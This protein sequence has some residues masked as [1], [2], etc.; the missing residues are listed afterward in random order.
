M[1]LIAMPPCPMLPRSEFL[2]SLTMRVTCLNQFDSAHADRDLAT[3]RMAFKIH[4]L[5]NPRYVQPLKILGL[6]LMW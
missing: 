1:V 6:P 4:Q 3:K 2:P 5:L